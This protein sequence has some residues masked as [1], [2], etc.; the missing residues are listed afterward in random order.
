YY[1]R[2]CPLFRHSFPTRR[3][4]DLIAFMLVVMVIYV[5]LGRATDTLI[6]VVAL[7]LSLLVTFTVMY[8][9]NFSVNNLTLMA[10]TLA[11]GFLVDRS[12]EHT[13]ELQSPDHLVCRLLL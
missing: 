7:P 4:S 11:I 1:S 13:S 12:E 2:R 8:M 5:F 3:S 6:P 9:L 10:L